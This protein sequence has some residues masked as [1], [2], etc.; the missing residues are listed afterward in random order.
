M[1]VKK[2]LV[3]LLAALLL[4]IG[5]GVATADD[6]NGTGSGDGTGSQAGDGWRDLEPFGD[7]SDVGRAPSRAGTPR[8]VGGS[9][10]NIRATPWQAYIEISTAEGT[11]SC[12][13]SVIAPQV[14]LT[15]AHC[16]DT[17]D[18][19]LAVTG[20]SNLDAIT[21]DDITEAVSLWVH[22]AWDPETFS[23]DVAIVLMDRNLPGAKVIPLF[24]SNGPAAN[25][26]VLISGW[27]TTSEGGS[28]PSQLQS[29]VI[30][31]LA[32]PGQG[33]GNY[34]GEF[35]PRIM[36]CAGIQGGGIDTC[37]GDSGGPAAVKVNGTYRVAGITSFGTGC[38]QAGFPGVYA[39]VSKFNEL[40][41]SVS[42][43]AIF[44]KSGR[45]AT[46]AWV[47]PAVDRK[48]VDYIIEYK[49]GRGR[50]QTL[51]D[52]KSTDTVVE[53][54]GLRAGT[55]YSFRVTAKLKGGGRAA[56]STN[57]QPSA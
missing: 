48:V 34:G 20:V 11:F 3:G 49:P 32:G 21:T 47:K 9:D 42:Y 44:Q 55:D 14:L 52:G 22:P 35:N 19:I 31:V 56:T 39:R 57:A 27:G 37:Q 51:D 15:A 38:A 46:V 54:T 24:K 41:T 6:T 40:I 33:C 36:L 10:T 18:S 26:R 50:W 25:T 29:A 13:A 53:I 8:I 23:N 16:T 17:A 7:L 45:R 5:S 4:P 30:R 1:R 43:F 12:G 2:V 28:S